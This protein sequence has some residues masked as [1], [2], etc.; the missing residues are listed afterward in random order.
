MSQEEVISVIVKIKKPLSRT[1]IAKILNQ[2]VIRV[3][4]ALQKLL[5]AKEI[6][7]T[8]IDR[9]KAMIRYGSKRRMRLYYL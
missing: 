9:E 3:S 2:D 6:K 4:H 1:E 7:S 8:E 5:K